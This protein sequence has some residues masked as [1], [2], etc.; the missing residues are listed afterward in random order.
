MKA[1]GLNA[2]MRASKSKLV[3]ISPPPRRTDKSFSTWPGTVRPRAGQIV[4]GDAA[5]D[6]PIGQP[7]RPR[8]QRRVEIGLAQNAFEFALPTGIEMDAGI[9]D[10]DR[11]ARQEIGAET[12]R[13][14]EP[15]LDADQ[16][17]A[18]RG[19]SL[20]KPA[21]LAR[22]PDRDRSAAR[23]RRND[24]AGNGAAE[25]GATRRAREKLG[26]TP[27]LPP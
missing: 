5:G 17:N 11:Y 24:R 22:R 9:V 2:R 10:D 13:A 27:A 12:D 7:P 14:N 19:G 23:L 15:V 21:G 25:H 18:V 26:D 16:G 4:F 3:R 1:S 8:H 20:G 6:E